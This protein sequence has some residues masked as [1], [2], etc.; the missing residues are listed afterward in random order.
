[1]CCNGLD[2]AGMRFHARLWL[3]VALGRKD[4]VWSRLFAMER[5]AHDIKAITWFQSYS[6][7]IPD[8]PDQVIFFPFV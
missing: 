3:N 4:E 2:F 7:W 8:R 5:F 6:T 1:M